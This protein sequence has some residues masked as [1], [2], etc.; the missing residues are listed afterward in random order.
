MKKKIAALLVCSL[1]ATSLLAGCGSDETADSASAEAE[2]EVITAETVLAATDYDVEDYVVL[3]DDYMKLAVEISSD[4][5]VT[6]ED[7]QEYIESYV[8][9]YY[10]MYVDSDKTT[11]EDGDIVDIDYVGTMDGEEFDGGSAEGY[12]LEIGSGTFIDGFEDGLIGAEVGSTLDLNLT[13]P[14]D[15]SS[16]DLAGQAVVFTVT[17]N[18]IQ[19][20]QTLTYDEMTDEYVESTFGSSYGYTTV[21][22]MVSDITL[23]MEDSYESSKAS[24]IQTEVMAQLEE[25][26]TVTLPDGLLDERVETTISDIQAA[27][28]EDGYEYVDYIYEYYGYEDEDEFSEYVYETLEEQL[29][30]ELILEAIVKDQDV[31]ISTADLA[32]FVESY[33]EYY[34]YDDD[35]AFYEAYGGEA[36][37]QLGYAENRALNLV[38]DAAEVTVAESSDADTSEE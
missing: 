7:V 19:E 11:V 5:E 26:C 22:E 25:G 23:S 10:P 37:V 21:D 28:E 13:F 3:M 31:S 18:S 6:D 16:E 33:V 20:E 24:E 9:A 14:D 27:A 4:Y 38:M 29:I 1:A 34:G 2:S 12:D 32:E 15:Y 8:L 35:E 36:Y 17:V 30:E